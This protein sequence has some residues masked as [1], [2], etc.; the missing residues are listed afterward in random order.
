MHR[1]KSACNSSIVRGREGGATA[2]TAATAKAMA[3][4]IGGTSTGSISSI[5]RFLALNGEGEGWHV[6]RVVAERAVAQR[7]H[8]CEPAVRF[9]LSP[10]VFVEFVKPARQTIQSV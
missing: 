7:P 4:F 6:R 8:I 3:E 5:F 10:R 2:A 1:R 9:P